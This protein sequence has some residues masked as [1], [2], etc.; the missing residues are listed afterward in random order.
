MREAIDRGKRGPAWDAQG[1]QQRDESK[2]APRAVA[3]A[4]K[5]KKTADSDRT[6]PVGAPPSEPRVKRP[7][8]AAAVAASL[9]EDQVQ[10]E[11]AEPALIFFAGLEQEH[12]RRV[13][14]AKHFVMKLKAPEP[15]EWDGVGGT[16]AKIHI[17][18]L[19]V[20]PTSSQFQCT[21][22]CAAA[23]VVLAGLS[24]HQGCIGG[25]EKAHGELQFL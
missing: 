14:W 1:R 15:S 13:E 3:A 2:N 4:E 17:A 12:H 5:R 24:S 25:A 8:A 7:R 22:D 9:F 23:V 19:S 16:V 10:Q 6:S 11:D 21:S 20:A 18:T